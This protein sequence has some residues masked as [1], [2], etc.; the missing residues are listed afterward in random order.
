MSEIKK[1][2]EVVLNQVCIRKVVVEVEPSFFD[3]RS[4]VDKACELAFKDCK[5]KVTQ[6]WTRL[7]PNVVRVKDLESGVVL[8]QK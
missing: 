2:V 3:N 7:S 1:K 4:L 5:E 8:L 6:E